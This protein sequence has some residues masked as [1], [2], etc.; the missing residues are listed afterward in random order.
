MKMQRMAMT[1]AAAVAIL[2][3]VAMVRAQQSASAPAPQQSAAPAQASAAAP[4][5]S[6]QRQSPAPGGN[7]LKAETREV[8]VDV[9]VTDKKGNY[10]KDL[11]QK[12]FRVWE[13]NKEVGVNTFSF[14]AD[15]SAPAGQQ[16]HY[17]VLYFD[18]ASMDLSDQPQAR[19]AAGKFID[20]NAGP[21]R[22][23]AVMDF[24]GT[25]RIEQ[26]FTADAAKLKQAVTNIQTSSVATN[27][28]ASTGGLSGGGL[29]TVGDP[30]ADFGTQSLLLS[31]RSVAKNLA[32]I[33]GRKSLIL[34]TAG[35]E[36]SP[37]RMSE[38][39]ATID[40][41]NKANVAVYP[42]DV[43][44]LTMSLGELRKPA[45]PLGAKSGATSGATTSAIFSAALRGDAGSPALRRDR[46]AQARAAAYRNARGDAPGMATRSELRCVSKSKA[47]GL[48]RIGCGARRETLDGRL[49]S[50]LGAHTSRDAHG[51][52]LVLVGSPQRVGGGGGGHVGGGGGGGTGGGGTGGKG[53]TGGTGGTGGSGGKGGT[54]GTGGTGGHTG[55]GG[56]YNGNYNANQTRQLVPQFPSSASTNQQVMYEL[57]SGTGGFPILNTNDLLGGLQKIAAEQDQYYLLGYNPAESPEGSCH[58]LK[59]KVDQGGMNVR[60]RSGYC[61]VHTNDVL[62]GKPIEK[63]LESRALATGAPAGAPNNTAPNA[64]VSA[65]AAAGGGALQT[66][67]FYTAPNEARVNLS[68]QIPSSSVVF[69]KEKGKYHADVNVLGVAYAPDGSV[70]AHF[71]DEVTLDMEKDEMKKFNETPMRYEN[72]FAIAPGKYTFKLVMSGGGDQFQTLE[73]PLVIDAF[74]GKK[75][76]LSTPV[77]SADYGR[78]A[79]LGDQLD[80]ALIA[81]Q[82]PLIVKGVKFNASSTN[83]FKKTEKV[84][85]YGQVYDPKLS[86]VRPSL[87]ASS[88]PETKPDGKPDAKP[89]AK[90]GDAAAPAAAAKGAVGIRAQFVVLDAKTG[91]QAY[92]SGGIDLDSFVDA[93]NPVVPFALKLP[94]DQL[95]PGDYKFEMQAGDTSGAVTQ[96]RIVT[97]SVE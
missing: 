44:G 6:A 79:D 58:T 5:Q 14:G 68:A 27:T 65:A 50:A 97:F 90:S 96:V 77:F 87:L 3:G 84:A 8:R 24:G 46:L 9:I 1:A 49:R 13:D 53:G 61:N 37:E 63:E 89:D 41:C 42:V 67:F 80:A 36:L 31:I 52:R 26:N 48:Y 76:A 64:P 11:T 78:V 2:S 62:A 15:S 25:L 55:G 43:R 72:Q 57:A 85:I 59:V 75:T 95:A 81:D 71:S 74:D 12:D 16:R 47:S 19:A 66:P 70:A 17:M 92:A 34:F 23:M 86:E 21:D 22:V 32:D 82:V 91:K 51:A 7:V 28:T 45:E 88:K 33:P 35:F 93:G 29:Q 56:V 30:E 60:A 73:G 83:H 38:L 20:A 39:T 54:G 4:A 94:V 69:N 40:A 10:V 18:N